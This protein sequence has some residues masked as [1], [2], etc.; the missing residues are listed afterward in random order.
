MKVTF[1]NVETKQ[2]VDKAATTTYRGS[3]TDKTERTGAF[4][5]DISGSVMDNKAYKGQGKT[6]EE[7]MQEAGQIDVATQRDY[8]TVMSNSMS[9]EDFGQMMKD[10]FQIGDMEVEEVVTIVDKIK[11]ALIKGGVEVVG[12]TD[13]IDEDTLEQITGSEA[14]AR[15][16]S[17]QFIEHDVPPTEENIENAVAA[18]DKAAE[19]KKLSEG[20]IRYM[21]ENHME[22]TID[23]LYLAEHSATPAADKQAKGYYECFTQQGYAGYYARKAED[24]HWQQ[25]RPQMREV[26]RQAGLPVNEETMEDAKWLIEKGIPLT[27]EAVTSLYQLNSLKLPQDGEQVMAAIASAIADGEEAGKANLADPRSKLEKAADYVDRFAQ[28]TDQALQKTVSEGRELTLANLE[29]AQSELEA[30]GTAPAEYREYAV[31]ND[32]DGVDGT[33][34][35]VYFDSPQAVTARRQLEEIRLM[36]TIEANLRLMKNG[37]YIDTTELQELVDALRQIET[38]QKQHMFR[39]TDMRRVSIKSSLYTE[40]RNKIAEIPLLPIDVAGKFKVTDKDFTLNQVHVA[41]TALKNEYEQASK[42][43][44]AWMAPREEMGDSIQKAFRNIDDILEDMKL[45]PSEENRRAIR[46]LGYNSMELTEEN[47]QL[48]KESDMELRR[49]IDKMTPAVVLQTIRENKNPL[50]MTIPELNDCLDAMQY[51]QE[52][53]EENYSKFL[54]KLDKSDGIDAVERTAYIGIYRLF[55]QI[56]KGDESALGTLV[57]TGTAKFSFK[58]LLSMMRSQ[59][60]FNMDFTIDDLFDGVEAIDDEDSI[61]S[62]IEGGFN[63][64]YRQIA[65]AIADRMAK[66]DESL[67]K[68]YEEEQIQEY[69]ESCKVEDDVIKELLDNKQPVTANNLAA[70]NM[71]M[72]KRG[73]LY[74]DLK[75]YTKPED[76]DKV[77]DAVSHLREAMTDKESTQEAY[78][79]MQHVFEEVLEEAQNAPDIRYLDLKAIQSCSKQLTL[80]GN[81]AQEENYQVPVEIHGETTAIH[82]KVLHGKKDGGKVKVAFATESY[83]QVAAEFS[84]RKKRISGYIACSTA[85]GAAN[86]QGREQNLRAGLKNTVRALATNELELGGISTVHS[87]ELNL[88]SFTAEEAENDSAVQTAELYQIAKAFITVVTA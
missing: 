33:S 28:V 13:Q 4:A 86:L 84:V 69:R 41:G 63:R 37:V 67:E 56:E 22:P 26:V 27:A 70:A 88:N 74:K 40:T 42:K 5:L 1:D 50:E 83:G 78:E 65:G 66:Q 34:S 73:S 19:L 82:L 31:D 44:E 39:D 57:N 29:A 72:Y 15:K 6:A 45:E 62:Q 38:Q 8:M 43:Y 79:E 55:R 23:N 49:V 18:Y 30:D 87:T 75:K 9:A 81:L 77:K 12:Y 64:N 60:K 20:A 58:N 76:N 51:S 14:F 7:V 80:A 52:Q 46:I 10:G 17:K 47:I 68:E 11:A 25:L 21:V 3:R 35:T 53:E 61:S 59:K 54:H 85:E 32:A 24:F 48:V 2:N 16:L 36:M 71:L